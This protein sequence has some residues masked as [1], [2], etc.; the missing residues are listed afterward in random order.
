MRKS[1][2]KE[3]G[4]GGRQ[5]GFPFLGKEDKKKG[6]DNKKETKHLQLENELLKICH[7]FRLLIM[8]CITADMLV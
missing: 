1:D 7:E 8:L 5:P 6:N 2:R 3:G 4:K